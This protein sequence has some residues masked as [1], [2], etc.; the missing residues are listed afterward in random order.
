ME[1]QAILI[2]MLSI[3]NLMMSYSGFSWIFEKHDIFL[4]ALDRVHHSSF[5]VHNN[6]TR[7]HAK[8]S[9]IEGLQREMS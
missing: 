2:S 1:N 9:G 7:V 4:R 8:K 3:V 5:I 6:P